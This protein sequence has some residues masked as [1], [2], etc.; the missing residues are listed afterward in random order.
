MM[1]SDQIREARTRAG[2]TQFAFAV[3]V[4]ASLPTVTRWEAG[5]HVPRHYLHVVALERMGVPVSAMRAAWDEPAADTG[6]S[7]PNPNRMVAA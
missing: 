1:L 4:G 6:R 3:R 7:I 5:T 2:L